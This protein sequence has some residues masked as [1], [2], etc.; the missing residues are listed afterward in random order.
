MLI[1]LLNRRGYLITWIIGGNYRPNH[2]LV[3]KF[4]VRFTKNLSAILGQ[5]AEEILYELGIG[6]EF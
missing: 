5:P 4:D 3:V 2:H 6:L 1:N